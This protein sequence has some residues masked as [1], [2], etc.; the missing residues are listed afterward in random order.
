M[1]KVDIGILCADSIKFDFI[2]EFILDGNPVPSE[3]CVSIDGDRLRFN[4][5]RY[6]TICFTP[7]SPNCSFVLHDVIIGVGFHWQRAEN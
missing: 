3:N 5:K 4:G 2:G 6:D 1:R 7:Q